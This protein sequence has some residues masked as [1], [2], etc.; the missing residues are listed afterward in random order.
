[1]YYRRN[2]FLQLFL[3]ELH[4]LMETP[5]CW[6]GPRCVFKHPLTH[7]PDRALCFG[8]GDRTKEHHSTCLY[9]RMCPCTHQRCTRDDVVSN[10]RIC[11][12]VSVSYLACHGVDRQM[13]TAFGIML[14]YVADLA[15]HSVHTTHIDGLNWRLML[16]SVRAILHFIPYTSM[17]N[18]IADLSSPCRPAYLLYWS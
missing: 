1:M 2:Q 18:L 4:E 7:F 5:L 9:G 16:G 17:A 3:A 10:R 13:W 8:I 15:L 14:G 12:G 6:S 11:V